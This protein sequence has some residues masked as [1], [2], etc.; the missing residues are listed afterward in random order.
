MAYRPPSEWTAFPAPDLFCYARRSVRRYWPRLH[1][2]DGEPLPDD[3]ELLEGWVAFHNGDF[4]R[5]FIAGCTAGHSGSTLANRAACA[6]ATYL[7]ADQDKQ[8]ALYLHVAGRA[9]ADAER[10][11]HNANAHFLYAFAL[12]RYSQH[13]R[14]TRA[15]ALGFGSDVKRALETALEVQPDHVESCVALG[16]FHAEIIDKVGPLIGNVAYGAKRE[17]SLAQFTRALA[18]QPRSTLAR[19]EYARALLM[20]DGDACQPEARQLWAQAAAQTPVDALD[21]LAIT[22]A[23]AG[24]PEVF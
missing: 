19:M 4:A 10:Q 20:L 1:A 3:P 8:L 18:L 14:V 22:Q 24:L 7:E 5:A 16:T 21:F 6:Y 17:T 11:P 13:I 12:G 9:A 15:L 23:Q 2:G